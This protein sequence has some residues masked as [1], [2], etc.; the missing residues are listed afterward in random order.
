MAMT[1]CRHVER[2]VTTFENGMNLNC[3]QIAIA[4][5]DT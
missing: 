3:V 1:M 4:K 5:R 2:H